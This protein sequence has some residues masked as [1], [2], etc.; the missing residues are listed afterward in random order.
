MIVSMFFCLLLLTAQA[1]ESFGVDRGQEPGGAVL[2]KAAATQWRQVFPSVLSEGSGFAGAKDMDEN[3]KLKRRSQE[4]LLGSWVCHTKNG[5]VSLNFISA[6][7][8]V[9]NGDTAYYRSTSDKIIV[10]ADGQMLTYPYYFS[11]KGLVITFPE[12]IKALFM[13]DT[14]GTAAAAAAGSIFPQL[15]GE[16]K[17]IRS[18]GNTVITL[19]GDGQY[20][21]YSDFAAGNSSAGETNWG[22]ANSNSDRGTWRAQ[23]TP[24]AGTIFYKSRDG[25]S[26]TLTYHVHVENGSTYWSEYYFDGTIYVKQ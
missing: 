21:Y 25:S 23:G 11:E 16:W 5:D 4:T 24:R 7:Q 10:Q 17:D 1:G 8:L 9:F 22:T 14:G 26:D 2:E 19:A 12:G 13:R 3:F 15:V 18:S 6:N 20:S